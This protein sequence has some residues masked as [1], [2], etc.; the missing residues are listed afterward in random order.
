MSYYS[1]LGLDQEPFSTSPDP[2]FLCMCREH[3]AALYKARIA[4]SLRRGMS[5]IIGDVGMGKT[6]ISRKL[7][8]VFSDDDDVLF[9]MILNPFFKSDKQ[10]LQRLAQLFKVGKLRDD[11]SEL[12]YIE[13]IER[14]LFKKGVEEDKTIVLLIDESQMIPDYVLEVLRVLLNYETNEHKLLQL[15]LVGQMEMLPTI[16]KIPNFWDRIAMKCVINPIT[17]EEAKE[18]IGFRLKSAG[19]DRSTPLFTDR[20][21]KRIWSHTEGY[22]RKMSMLCHNCLEY[23]VMEDKTVVDENVVEAVIKTELKPIEFE[24]EGV[25]DVVI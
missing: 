11:A 4:V 23:L 16:S 22:P 2:N 18:I 15:I 13:A 21:I 1:Q 7:S 14:F 20:A 10:F 5:V 25:P 6:T 17:Q 8:Q 24:F 19:F 9:H 3:K 12:D